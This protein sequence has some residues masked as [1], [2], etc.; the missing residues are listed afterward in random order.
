MTEEYHRANTVKVSKFF[1]QTSPNYWINY[2]FFGNYDCKNDFKYYHGIS[3]V[4]LYIDPNE[5]QNYTS[6]ERYVSNCVPGRQF[7][8]IYIK[9]GNK[10]WN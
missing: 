5:F 2:C 3:G 9:F 6:T 1:E 8:V 7:D 10:S 4:C